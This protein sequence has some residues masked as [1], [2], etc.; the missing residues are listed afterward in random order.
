MSAYNEQL[1]D[2][3]GTRDLTCVDGWNAQQLQGLTTQRQELE[4]SSTRSLPAA[5]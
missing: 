4:G 5:S 2:I 1:I 3:E